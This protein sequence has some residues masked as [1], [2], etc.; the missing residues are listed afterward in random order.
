KVT[1]FDYENSLLIVV[2]TPDNKRVDIDN[3]LSFKNVVKIDHHP[4]VDTFGRVE[5][6]KDS[7][8]SASELVLLLINNTKLKMNEN[9]A[10]NL[11][12]GIVSD[13][14]RFL[15]NVN[16][17]TFLLV[18]EL[19]K[20]Y[21]LD[22]DKIYRQVY[23]RPLSEIRL[24]GYIASTIK[25]DKYG[26]AHLEIDEDVITSLG[27]DISSVSNMINDFNNIKE[28]LVWVF[29]THDIKNN[30]YKVNIRSRGPVIN[31]IAAK[32]NG[33]GHAYAS[34]VRTDK[35]ENIDA[36]LKDL[37]LCCKEYKESEEK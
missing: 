6:I 30:L 18:S 29:V 31:L 34:G 3:F 24:L 32:Y 12:T 9:I 25:V 7:A 26:F 16:S 22:I 36:L 11:Y 13:T 1:D 5:L 21:K 27:A 2:D 8:S 10:S 15:V 4:K 35:K 33:G 37:S 19:I 17:N 28:V 23:K 20:K 14:N